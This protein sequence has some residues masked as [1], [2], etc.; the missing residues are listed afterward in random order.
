MA[1]T[2]SGKPKAPSIKDVA[3]LAGVS[4]PT[5]SRYLNTPERVSEAKRVMIAQAIDKLGYRPNAIARALVREQ[6]RQCLVLSANTTLY[7]QTQVIQGVEMAAHDA[8]FALGIGVISPDGKTITRDR[9][10]SA[11]DHNPAG[12]ILLNFDEAS[13]QAL[14]LI[15]VGLP[16][17]CIA[18]ERNADIAQISMGERDGGYRMTSYLLQCLAQRGCRQPIVHYVGIPGGGGAEG[19]Y[20][21]WLQACQEAGVPVPA[22]IEADWNVDSARLAGR[23][24]GSMGEQVKAVFAGND[25]TAMGVI[26]GLEDQGLHVPDD[27]IVAGFDDHPVAR[28][29]NPSITTIRQDFQGMGVAAFSMLEPMMCD[30][31]NARPHGRQWQA[32]REFRG[33]LIVRESTGCLPVDGLVG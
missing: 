31:A 16:L 9:I 28:I 18:G 12:I 27:V 14:P 26:R 29:W 32:R 1:K 8:D 6:S 24:L 13:A 5:V 19:R 2:P 33:E 21:G 22:P 23:E 15:P 17:V 25:E 10:L 20:E 7:G 4:V 3:A 30:V 11:L